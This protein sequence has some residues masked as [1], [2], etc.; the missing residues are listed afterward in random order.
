MCSLPSC[1][2]RF[3][4]PRR[5]FKLEV[6]AHVGDAVLHPFTKFEVRRLSS[7]EDMAHFRSRC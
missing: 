4:Q 2:W 6:T 3:E 1:K 7:S 5:A